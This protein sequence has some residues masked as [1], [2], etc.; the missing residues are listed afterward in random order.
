MQIVIP[1]LCERYI[2]N[3]CVSCKVF[4]VPENET[5][6]KCKKCQQAIACLTNT[7]ANPSGEMADAQDF[8]ANQ[9]IK[10]SCPERGGGSSPP[11]GT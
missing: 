3:Q 9:R 5:D 1:T 6:E 11:S 8:L 2:T 7:L 4:F 10:G